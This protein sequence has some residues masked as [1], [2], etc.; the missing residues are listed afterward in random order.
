MNVIICGNVILKGSKCKSL[1]DGLGA[2]LCIVTSCKQLNAKFD[3]FLH[4]LHLILML[5]SVYVLIGTVIK[6]SI[7][8]KQLKRSSLSNIV[9]AH[10]SPGLL[11]S[12]DT[13]IPRGSSSNQRDSFLHLM[14]LIEIMLKPYVTP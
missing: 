9:R 1:M 10:V 2:I 5:L 8:Y 13:N 12:V 3:I 6:T 7:L 4:F 14:T 11:N